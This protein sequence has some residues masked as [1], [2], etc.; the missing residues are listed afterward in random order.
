MNR[1][2]IVRIAARGD[3]T[4]AD[5]RHAPLTAPGDWL[6][7]DGTIER[8]PAHQEPPCR[9]FPRCG[10]C[11]LQHVGD[12]AYADYLQQRVAGALAAQGLAARTIRPTHLSP[13]NKRRRAALKSQKHGNS[14]TLGF[15]QERT[16]RIVD[17]RECHV[18]DPRLFALTAPLRALMAIALGRN[19]TAQIQ[20]TLADQGVDV[21]ITGVTADG[22]AAAEALQDFAHGHALARLAIDAGDGPEDRWHPDPVTVTLG[23]VAVALPHAAFLQ[24]TADGEQAL[25][26]AV[27]E[28]TAGAAR[29][30]DLFA[31]LGTFALPLSRRA[32]VTAVEASR[33]PVTALQRA[34]NRA[35]RP[36]ATQHRDLYRRPMTAEELGGEDAV[37]LDPPRAGAEEQVRALA[38][39]KVP[40]IAYAS[41]NP[42][43]FARDATFLVNGGYAL[44]WVQPIGQFNWSTHL[45]LVARFA[46]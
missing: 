18:L 24:A 35:H 29:V 4:T 23:G 30:T 1:S 10:G 25:L 43:T 17:M 15:N 38:T 46:R 14:I 7:A 6:Y 45:E 31:G 40:V 19:G 5:G 20:L 11:Q 37:I 21:L 36:V 8:G 44:D 28:I 22:L 34:A 32:T 41:C 27:E 13:S 2:E 39:S 3:G 9:H 33:A 12:A 16:H 42:A 26:A